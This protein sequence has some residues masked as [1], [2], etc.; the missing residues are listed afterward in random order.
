MKVGGLM[1]FMVAGLVASL[2][3]M[4]SGLSPVA[5][6]AEEVSEEYDRLPGVVWGIGTDFQ[7]EDS[8]YVDI[9][10]TSTVPVNVRIQSI[11]EMVT[12][13]VDQTLAND[14]TQFTFS[15]LEPE[16]IYYKYEDNFH[17]LT[18]FTTDEFG[19]YS[20]VQDL[21]EAHFI[22]I[23]SHKSTHFIKDD[24][25]GGDCSAI[26]AWNQSTKTCKL[27]TDVTETIQIDSDG[28]TLDGNGYRSYNPITQWGYGVYTDQHSHITVKN[29]SFSNLG[30]GVLLSR[31]E[32]SAVFDNNF[33]D[34]SQ[35]IYLIYAD[36]SVV[37]DN[38]IANE[39]AAGGGI[40]LARSFYSTIEN[41]N[42]SGGSVGVNLEN[43]FESTT[44]YN[45]ITGTS[46]RNIRMRFT[47]RSQIYNNNFINDPGR[48]LITAASGNIFNLDAPIGGNFW[49]S[50]DTPE[51]GCNDNNS[52]GFCDASLAF[53]G[54]RDNLPHLRPITDPVELDIPPAILFLPGLQGSRL[55]T[56]GDLFENKLWEPNRNSDVEKLFLDEEGESILSGV[57]TRDIIDEAFGYNIYKNF[58]IFMDELVADSV[59]QEW[60]A[61]PYDW[62]LDVDQHV[63]A[64]IEE[65][66]SLAAENTK[67]TIIAH[68]NG[69]LIAKAVLQELERQKTAGEN[70]LIDSIDQLI[71]VAVPQSGTPKTI[72]SMLHGYD[73]DYAKGLLL[74][75]V[76][77][78]TM[79]EHMAS[80][81]NLLPSASY[82]DQVLDPVVEF[83]ESADRF[84]LFRSLYGSSIDS[85]SELRSLLTGGSG[86]WGQPDASDIVS[87]FVLKNHFINTAAGRHLDWHE[88]S[89]PDHIEVVQIAGWGL[90]TVKS[91]QYKAKKTL[92]C[93]GISPIFCKD[94]YK[95]DMRPVFTVDGDKTVVVP[96]AV[97]MEGKEYYLNLHDYNKELFGGRRNR[98]HADIFEAEPLHSLLRTILTGTDDLPL[99]VSNEP[100][101]DEDIDRRIRASVH[102]PVDISLIDMIGNR[103]GLVH[104]SDLLLKEEN[105]INSYYL[106]F[107]EGKYVGFDAAEP[108]T[109][110]LNAVGNGMFTLEF[111]EVTTADE[112]IN[113]LQYENIPVVAGAA[114]ELTLQTIDE[115][116]PLHIDFNGDGTFDADVRPGEQLTTEQ[117]FDALEVMIE[118][119]DLKE[120]DRTS[121]QAH[122]QNAH[123]MLNNEKTNLKSVGSQFKNVEKKISKVAGETISQEEAAV[124][125]EV[126]KL[127]KIQLDI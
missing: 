36:N 119:L 46:F 55:Y 59:I 1:Q 7:V 124:V 25:T 26:G 77:A 61:A 68:S 84:V 41:N 123:K 78:R 6:A 88:W 99:H 43:V 62:R 106:E 51:E 90:D 21:S 112:V 85:P 29:F 89:P 120:G 5:L 126:L 4:V 79:A 93:S 19:S 34:N 83:D 81:F 13:F 22:T 116:G 63:P 8:D 60:R 74:N 96:S 16:T 56:Q 72:A 27:A 35:G 67:I 114:A 104:N 103:T 109:I 53:N 33:T 11:P 125:I 92:S 107:G 39:G 108:H 101:G 57:Y 110:E 32:D 127:I 87:P 23:Q 64:M 48:I 24:A 10:L 40:H 75:K 47:S 2:W 69:G 105:V 12:V 76:T 115:S 65:I 15:G 117:L 20:Y 17:N 52:D 9:G 30:I 71:M 86:S 80:A 58:M 45:S 73:L 121:I 95:L 50:F 54:G 102:S 14:S 66:T 94:G 122:L 31:S 42:V 37:H 38:T 44:R 82:F 100:E 3:L 91:V 111:E 118:S 113:T 49:S 18:T 98:S 70:D 28:I 97:T